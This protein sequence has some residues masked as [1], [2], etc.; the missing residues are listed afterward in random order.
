MLNTLAA[1]AAF[2][3]PYFLVIANRVGILTI[4]ALCLRP[5]LVS[6]RT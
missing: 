6:I 3:V 2:F 1:N 4:L 5:H